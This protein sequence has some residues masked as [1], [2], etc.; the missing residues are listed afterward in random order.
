[1]AKR[2]R[3]PKLPTGRPIGPMPIKGTNVIEFNF[4]QAMVDR[5]LATGYAPV[6]DTQVI[7]VDFANGK[8]IGHVS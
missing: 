4:K 2:Q 5:L 1:M 6:Y 8:K 7:Y 3:I